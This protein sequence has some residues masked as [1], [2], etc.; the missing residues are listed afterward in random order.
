VPNFV[1][2]AASIAEL[3]L[4]EKPRIH[5]LTHSPSLFDTPGTEPNLALRNKLFSDGLVSVKVNLPA[6]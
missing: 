1:S 4:G 3:A 2:F 6:I 5:S